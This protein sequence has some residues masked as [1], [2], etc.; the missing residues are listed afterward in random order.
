MKSAVDVRERE[1]DLFGSTAAGLIRF[2][3]DT[4]CGC[5]VEV[6]YAGSSG[7]LIYYRGEGSLFATATTTHVG[8]GVC[9]A[10]VVNWNGS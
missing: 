6:E 1:T 5:G 4:C 10:A 7:K 2:D 3:R 9:D 8:I